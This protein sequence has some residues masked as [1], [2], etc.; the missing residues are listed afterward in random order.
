[1]NR[2]GWGVIKF[3]PTAAV[4]MLA[5]LEAIDAGLKGKPQLFTDES[6]DFN[7]HKML[8]YNT[9][10]S[11]LNVINSKAKE[12]RALEEAGVSWLMAKLASARQVGM[13]SIPLRDLLGDAVSPGSPTDISISTP[14]LNANESFYEQDETILP[15]ISNGTAKYAKTFNKQVWVDA[16]QPCKIYKSSPDQG[17]DCMV[18]SEREGA[19]HV[20]FVDMQSKAVHG[21]SAAQDSKPERLDID[22]YD[23]VERV[24]EELKK[25]KDPSKLSKVSRALVAGN[26]TFVFMTTGESVEPYRDGVRLDGCPSKVVIM[27]ERHTKAFMGILWDFYRSARSVLY[28]KQAKKE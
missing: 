13:S 9:F 1:M 11:I 17:Y 16:S 25:R 24:V 2:A 23:R 6:V 3:T 20:L 12:G 21:N 7:N 18:V 8:F 28:R 15:P 22:G 19:V 4:A 14:Y 26:Y 27:E 10:V 5:A